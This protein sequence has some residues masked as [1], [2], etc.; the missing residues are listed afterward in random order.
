M[1]VRGREVTGS[2]GRE[3]ILHLSSL[4]LNVLG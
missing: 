2:L 4:E 1:Q 3:K